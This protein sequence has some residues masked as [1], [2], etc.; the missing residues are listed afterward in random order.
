MTDWRRYVASLPE[1]TVRAAAAL[2]GGA[3]REVSEVALPTAVRGSKL[4]EATVARLLR[5]IVEGVGGVGGVY[6]VDVGAMPVR[7]LMTRKAAGNVLEFASILAMGSSPLWWLAAAADV[8]GGSKAYL[9]ALVGEL[10]ESKLLP[11]GTDVSSFDGLLSELE[12]KSGTLADAV[13]VPPM[14]LGDARHAWDRLRQQQGELP[15]ADDL[16]TLFDALQEAARR[17]GRSVSEVS[18][19]VGL[20]AARAGIELGTT[21]VVDYYREALGE[22]NREGM[23]TFLQR[24]SHPYRTQIGR[25]FAPSAATYTDQVLGWVGD[26]RERRRRGRQLS[27]DAPAETPMPPPSDASEAPSASG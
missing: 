6:P 8:S 15:G 3:V 20:A 14:N 27:E 19:A 2:G 13:D 17:E 1:R 11:A 4:Y 5:I 26:R 18:A 12:A 25:H 22:I 23:L 10:E 21:H 16:S 24:V 9:K 7:E